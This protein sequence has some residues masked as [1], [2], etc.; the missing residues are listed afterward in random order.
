[1]ILYGFLGADRALYRLFWWD[2]VSKEVDKV[3]E[4]NTWGSCSRSLS[5]PPPPISWRVIDVNEDCPH[6]QVLSVWLLNTRSKDEDGSH[7]V[8]C[9]GC[10]RFSIVLGLASSV[11]HRTWKMACSRHLCGHFYCSIPYQRSYQKLIVP[12]LPLS[13]KN[14]G[15]IYTE[16][17]TYVNSHIKTALVTGPFK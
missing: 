9:P 2:P 5:L 15:D 13:R 14:A 6:S 4:D 10:R 1:M 7:L 8:P 16:E 12:V 3:S 17:P 11:Q